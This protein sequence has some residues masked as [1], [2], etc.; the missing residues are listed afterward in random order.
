M[1]DKDLVE[2]I[3]ALVRACER[4]EKPGE[5]DEERGK[6]LLDFV[7]KRRRLQYRITDDDPRRTAFDAATIRGFIDPDELEP[8]H[9]ITEAFLRRLQKNPT[10]AVAYLTRHLDARNAA[11]SARAKKERTRDIFTHLIEDI[12]EDQPNIRAKEVERQLCARDD[13]QEDQGQLRYL[14]DPATM[15]LSNLPSR[16]SDAK[17]R[18][19]RNSS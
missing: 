18:L 13:V 8:T 11:Q 19:K 4:E 1:A 17:K 7:L 10:E 6:A 14:N 2:E 12:V 15:R 5:T 16:V 9:S 3:E